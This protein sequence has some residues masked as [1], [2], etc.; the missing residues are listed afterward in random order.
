[1]PVCQAFLEKKFEI[2]KKLIS[3]PIFIA[4]LLQKAIECDI[5]KLN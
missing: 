4:F 5:I 3:H 1:M 2:L